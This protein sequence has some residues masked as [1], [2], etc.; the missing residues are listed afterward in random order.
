MTQFRR[1]G[2][3]YIP[4]EPN[5]D[6]V[7]P[8]I[9]P[10]IYVVKYNE[11][12]QIYYLETSELF[13]LPSK[14][15]GDTLQISTRILTTYKDRSN[16]TGVMLSG[17]KGSGKTLL[18]KTVCMQAMLDNNIPTIMVNTAYFG[19]EFNE[20]IQSITQDCIVL[21]DE[22]EKTYS[23]PKHQEQILTLLDGVFSGH[24]LYMFTINEEKLINDNLRNRPGRIFYYKVFE[25]LNASFISE[26]CHD[27][28]NNK[29]HI[30]GVINVSY[31]FYS[32]NFDMLAGMV[33]EMNRY[34]E[35]A[36]EVIKLLNCKPTFDH[37]RTYLMYTE[38]PGKPGNSNSYDDTRNYKPLTDEIT[39]DVT[40]YDENDDYK[41]RKS[42]NLSPNTISSVDFNKGEFIYR[43]PENFVVRMVEYNENKFKTTLPIDIQKLL[44]V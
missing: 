33:Q 41:G 37:N 38:Y 18:T 44:A 40:L 17:E 34:N 35:S 16:S 26:Y 3:A 27:N 13:T 43:F 20:F 9:P 24:K 4:Y 36:A 7:T 12:Q 10:G 5:S 14:Y 39:V 23:N 42:L 32:F 8:T 21:F 22:F 31:S 1:N 28:L 6:N 19:D 15:Y 11:I 29:D 25:G 30:N 2:T